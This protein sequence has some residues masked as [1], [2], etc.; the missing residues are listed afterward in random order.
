[1]EDNGNTI[2]FD[3]EERAVAD[4][5]HSM[6]R[7]EAL[8][9]FLHVDR[10]RTNCAASIQEESAEELYG[11][12]AWQQAKA[13]AKFIERYNRLEAISRALGVIAS[14]E[15]D[16]QSADKIVNGFLA[17]LPGLHEE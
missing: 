14:E 3:D 6:A 9:A 1:M 15:L 16:Q 7:T 10:R 17:G 2:Y 11:A 8:E 5:P 13:I 12:Q 4:L